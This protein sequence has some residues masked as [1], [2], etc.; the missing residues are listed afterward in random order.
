MQNRASSDCFPR[1]FAYHSGFDL[2][3]VRGL[4]ERHREAVQAWNLSRPFKR[5][6][7]TTDFRRSSRIQGGFRAVPGKGFTTRVD[8][9]DLESI[10]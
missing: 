9:I 6:R 5:S 4:L 2:Q 10:R 8:V 7:E 3:A 1:G